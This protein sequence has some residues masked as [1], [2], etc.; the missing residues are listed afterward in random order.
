MIFFKF[1]LCL[2][3]DMI[4]AGQ[5]HSHWLRVR[6]L[7]TEHPHNQK[8]PTAAMIVRQIVQIHQFPQLR[9]YFRVTGHPVARSGSPLQSCQDKRSDEERL[10]L[11]C[12]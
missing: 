10:S 9:P 4:V 6:T 3:Y 1:I 11:G 5:G 8:A 7:T 2:S 12:I